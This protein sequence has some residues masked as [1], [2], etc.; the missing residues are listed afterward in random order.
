MRID[1][2]NKISEMYTAGSV[3][4]ATKAKAANFSDTLEISEMGKGYQ[5]AKQAV[6]RTP[7]VRE[8]KIKDIKER[9]EAGTYNIS[10]QDVVDKLV[11]QYLG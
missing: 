7:D 4:S 8:E 6:A 3:K 5:V 10:I 9:M 2:F 11:D 1:A